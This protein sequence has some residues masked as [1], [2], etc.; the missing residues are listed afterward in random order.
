MDNYFT[1]ETFGEYLP[2]NWEE[3][4]DAL[5]RLVDEHI[6]KD[7]NANKPWDVYPEAREWYDDLWDKFLH[8][9]LPD[10]P[11]PIMEE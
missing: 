1:A 7:E 6:E 2:K 5:N 4:V 9:E 11:K 3:I 10:V 8:G